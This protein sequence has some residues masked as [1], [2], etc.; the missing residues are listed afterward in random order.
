MFIILFLA[1]IHVN[2]SDSHTGRM[3]GCHGPDTEC[4][5]TYVGTCSC[6][7]FYTI[8]SFCYSGKS[9]LANNAVLF[10]VLNYS[11]SSGITYFSQLPKSKCDAHLQRREL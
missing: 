3:G 7:L 4:C 10:F 5:R 6:Y 9:S 1:G 2:V 11:H 8:S